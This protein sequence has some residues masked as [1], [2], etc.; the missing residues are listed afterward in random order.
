MAFA[1]VVLEARNWRSLRLRPKIAFWC[2]SLVHWADLEGPAQ[3]RLDP[4]AAQFGYDRYLRT[5]G[6]WNRRIVFSNTARQTSDLT[7]QGR[8]LAPQFSYA[9]GSA[10]GGRALIATSNAWA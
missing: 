5:A 2:F 1:L 9:R 10:S 8:S 4:F 6:G 3:G 7:L